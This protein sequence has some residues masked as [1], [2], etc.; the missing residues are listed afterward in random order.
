M[1][2]HKVIASVVKSELKNITK[3][4]NSPALQNGA[5][6]DYLFTELYPEVKKIANAQLRKMGQ[7]AE[8]LPT[9]L[10]NEY[11]IKL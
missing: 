10:V 5:Q 4:L 11:F 8:L 1:I 6:V 7:Q 2:G 3:I 9:M